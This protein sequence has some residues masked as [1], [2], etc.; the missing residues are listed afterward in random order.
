MLLLVRLRAPLSIGTAIALRALAPPGLLCLLSFSAA[1]S[2][3]VTPADS[4][5]ACA[6]VLALAVA[7]H[8]YYFVGTARRIAAALGIRVL[9]LGP[10]AAPPADKAK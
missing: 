5:S 6:T 4:T 1:A 2:S 7:L 10:A 9:R 8:L 3:G